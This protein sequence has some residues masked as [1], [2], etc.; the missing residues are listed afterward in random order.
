MAYQDDALEVLTLN[1]MLEGERIGSA[2]MLLAIEDARK[3][4]INR[5]WLTT[6][7]DNIAALA[8]YQKLGFRMTAVNLGVVDEARKAKPEIPQVGF[9]GIRVRDEVVFELPIKAYLDPD[10]S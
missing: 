9:E 4:N 10:P 2:L 8:F 5:I 3:R 7:N 1:S 6:T